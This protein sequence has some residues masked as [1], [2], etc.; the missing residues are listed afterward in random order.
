M[1]AKLLVHRPT[2]LEAIATMRR[3]LGEFVIEGIKTTI[4]I[5]REIMQNSAFIEGHVDTTFI[6]R[7]WLQPKN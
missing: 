1:I 2:R 5:H 7:T 6:E 3:A 4:P